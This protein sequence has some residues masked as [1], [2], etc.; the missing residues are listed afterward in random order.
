MAAAPDASRQSDPQSPAHAK[1]NLAEMV[2]LSP[3]RLLPEARG[4]CKTNL[5][6]KVS[7]FSARDK[8]C[9]SWLCHAERSS[10]QT[11]PQTSSLQALI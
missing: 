4:V 6:K 1:R 9:K 8:A 7:N 2:L 11:A 10:A 5:S 3:P